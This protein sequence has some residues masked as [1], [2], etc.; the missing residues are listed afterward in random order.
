MRRE[1]GGCRKDFGHH[2]FAVGRTVEAA[3]DEQEQD[4]PKIKVQKKS[5]HKPGPKPTSQKKGAKR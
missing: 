3:G 4:L 2:P 5:H 1:F